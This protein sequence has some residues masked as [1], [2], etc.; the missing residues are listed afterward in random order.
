MV[1]RRVDS[2]METDA[3]GKEALVAKQT[4]VTTG[5]TR[6]DQIAVLTGLK[7]GDEI[8]SSGQLKLQN[9]SHVLVDNKILPSNDPN[10][11]PVER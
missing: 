10:P 3:S 2:V 6:G 5:E 8:V 11:H 9:G 7:E 1:R 4:V